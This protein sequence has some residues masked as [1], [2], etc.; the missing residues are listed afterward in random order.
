M[1]PGGAS[2]VTT[3]ETITLTYGPFERAFTWQN[4]FFHIP[5]T[6]HTTN[7]A[8][9]YLE[10]SDESECGWVMRS[11]TSALAMVVAMEDLPWSPSLLSW[12]RWSSCQWACL[13][14]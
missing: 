3:A 7:G 6:T 1:N 8:H 12:A 4:A 2:V 13:S 5:I 14:S 10:M 9:A 11:W